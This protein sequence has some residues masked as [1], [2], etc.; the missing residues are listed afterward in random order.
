MCISRV[1]WSGA[2]LRT[3]ATWPRKPWGSRWDRVDISYRSK[4]IS[5]SGFGGHCCDIKRTIIMASNVVCPQFIFLGKVMK[6][7]GFILKDKLCTVKT[8]QWV[9]KWPTLCNRLVKKELWYQ[10]AV[11]FWFAEI[12]N[13][14]KSKINDRGLNGVLGTSRPACP[15]TANEAQTLAFEW[16]K[17]TYASVLLWM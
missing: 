11:P 4:C 8:V 2:L 5:T 6:N 7:H 12:R 16:G 1:G 17:F 15:L 10:C 9:P 3:L 13:A 14:D